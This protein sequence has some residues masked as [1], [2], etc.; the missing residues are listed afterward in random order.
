MIHIKDEEL[1]KKFGK[2]VRAKRLSKN[3][4]QQALANNA[5]VELSQIY[6]IEHGKINPTLST[7]NAIANAL[8]IPLKNLFDFEI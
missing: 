2:A 4:S 7:I 6:R 5:E 8:E 1:I 3:L